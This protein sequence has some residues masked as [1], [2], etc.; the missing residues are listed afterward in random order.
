M[1]LFLTSSP[2]LPPDS[3][4]LPFRLN[5]ANGFCDHLRQCL[6]ACGPLLLISAAPDR[7]RFNDR[8][9]RDFSL[10]LSEEGLCS[11]AAWI[12]DSRN[13]VRMHEYLAAA[14][15]VLLCGGHV[16]TQQRF[17]EQVGLRAALADYDGVIMGISAGSMNAADLVYA[18]PELP[19]EALCDDASRFL[20]GLALTKISILPHLQETRHIELDGL[21]LYED[22]TFRDSFHKPFFAFPDGS[23]IWQ[24]GSRITAFGETYRIYM[25]K[26]DPIC[27]NNEH[28]ELGGLNDDACEEFSG[29]PDL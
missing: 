6:T 9:L 24:C 5:P 13:I 11:E 4:R 1:N 23:Y 26:M 2:C 14:S 15:L 20:A 21:R 18:Q 10:V 19:G 16:P 25:G 22:V 17:L 12:L 29:H 3:S 27:R 28:L 7:H 8:M